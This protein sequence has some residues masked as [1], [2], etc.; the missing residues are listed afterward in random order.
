MNFIFSET[1]FNQ[2]HFYRRLYMPI[3]LLLGVVSPEIWQKS[4][5]IAKKTPYVGSRSFKVIDSVTNRK[6][7]CD[8]LL[9]VSGSMWHGFGTSYGDSLV[10]NRLC[11]ILFSFY[12]LATRQGWIFA[13]RLTNL[14]VAKTRYILLSA[15][16]DRIFLTSFVLAFVTIP[17][18]VKQTDGQT[19][20]L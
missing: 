15:S 11:E 18:C 13:N 20:M 4:P 17:A 8:F 10:R 3:S 12:A 5:K 2:L 6:V 7:M 9:V 1:T 14:Y 19:E 16:E